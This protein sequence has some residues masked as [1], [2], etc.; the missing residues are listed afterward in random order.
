MSSTC[1]LQRMR[2]RDAAK[3]FSGFGTLIL[4]PLGVDFRVPEDDRLV[5]VQAI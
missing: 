3:L 1:F 5:I 2:M 4:G